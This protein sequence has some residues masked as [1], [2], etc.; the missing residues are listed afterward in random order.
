MLQ[1]EDMGGACLV[2]MMGTPGVENSHC[3]QLVPI[4]QTVVRLLPEL[5]LW[6]WKVREDGAWTDL[7]KSQGRIGAELG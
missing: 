5:A 7:P 6:S 1:R 3:H 4:A 2:E